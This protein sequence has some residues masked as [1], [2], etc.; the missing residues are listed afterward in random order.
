MRFQVCCNAWL[1]TLAIQTFL[2]AFFFLVISLLDGYPSLTSAQFCSVFAPILTAIAIVL[3]LIDFCICT[4][5][6]SSIFGGVFYFLAMAV[7]CGVF[8]IIADPVFCF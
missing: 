3:T 2:I 7:Q 8:G 5:R 6:G 1:Y 4:F